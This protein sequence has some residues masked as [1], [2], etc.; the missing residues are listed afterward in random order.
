[1]NRE[2]DDMGEINSLG[3]DRFS[4]IDHCN[5]TASTASQRKQELTSDGVTAV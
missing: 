3:K 2:I 1:M 5:A 4:N